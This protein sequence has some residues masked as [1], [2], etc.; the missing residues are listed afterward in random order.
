MVTHTHRV[1]IYS[2]EKFYEPVTLAEW[3]TRSKVGDWRKNVV[4]TSLTKAEF[5]QELWGYFRLIK[6]QC[7]TVGKALHGLGS[8]PCNLQTG[9]LASPFSFISLNLLTSTLMSYSKRPVSVKRLNVC[10]K[11]WPDTLHKGSAQFSRCQSAL[12]FQLKLFGE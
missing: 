4:C 12:C 7:G 6:S 1:H 9:L 10:E 2:A 3:R 11:N 8:W 5:W